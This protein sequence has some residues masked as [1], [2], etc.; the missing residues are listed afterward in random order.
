M[1]FDTIFKEYYTLFRGRATSFPT[2]GD[3][4]FSV[5][6]QFA[7]NAIR[8]WERADGQLWRELIDT[9]QQQSTAI[10]ANDQRTVIAGQ[11]N[12]T[13]PSNM[14]KPPAF[15][16]FFDG[17]NQVRI[18][19]IEPQDVQH[20]PELSAVCYFS[21]SATKGFVLHI[22]Q[23]LSEQYEGSGIDFVYYKNATLFSTTADPSTEIPEM[24]DPNFIIQDMLASRYTNTRNGFGLNV[25][26]KE[27]TT[28]LANMKIENNSGVYSNAE[29]LKQYGSGWG[30]TLSSDGIQL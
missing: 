26:K 19:C 12:Y 22:G 6:I 14:R 20:Y 23:V 27:A 21:G 8:K 9:A 25:S 29:M 13:A 15:I 30:T 28:A 3:R 4:E 11:L 24:S 1:N 5:A 17:N 7:N 10:W 18:N 2:Y 16:W